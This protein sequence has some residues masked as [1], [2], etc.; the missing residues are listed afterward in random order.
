MSEHETNQGVAEFERALARAAERPPGLTPQQARNR[1]LSLLPPE[2]EPLVSWRLAAATVL[3]AALALASW[4]GVPRSRSQLVAAQNAALPSDV[5]VMKL[6]ESTTVY[7]FL[8]IEKTTG[9]AS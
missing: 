9:G 4:L 2:K 6:D 8:G 7:F 5:L 1:V 3:L